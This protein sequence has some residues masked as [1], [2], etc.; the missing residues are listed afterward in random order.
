MLGPRSHSVAQRAPRAEK[1]N[2]EAEKDSDDDDDERAPEQPKD[3][4]RD[5]G[6]SVQAL[7]T[8][9]LYVIV[10]KNSRRQISL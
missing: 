4:D 1:V 10:I 5:A 9:N 3:S 7:D 8:S 6:G 2:R